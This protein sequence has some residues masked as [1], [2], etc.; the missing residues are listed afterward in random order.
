MIL[1]SHA[2]LIFDALCTWSEEEPCSLL[3]HER[4]ISLFIQCR[5]VELISRVWVKP[6]CRLRKHCMT[7]VT[8]LHLSVWTDSYWSEVVCIHHIRGCTFTTSRMSISTPVRQALSP[9]T[10][11]PQQPTSMRASSPFLD[12]TWFHSTFVCPG[13]QASMVA[14]QVPDNRCPGIASGS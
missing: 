6:P 2:S 7:F 4:L 3:W 11:S 5:Q 13:T 14:T 10:S 12:R 9:T 8:S 1:S